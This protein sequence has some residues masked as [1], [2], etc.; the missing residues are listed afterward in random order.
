MGGYLW[1]IDS[2]NK[3]QGGQGW[4]RGAGLEN[5]MR[6]HLDYNCFQL[7]ECPGRVPIPLPVLDIVG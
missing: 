5:K 4:G 7:P 3:L 6:R 1:L 2:V